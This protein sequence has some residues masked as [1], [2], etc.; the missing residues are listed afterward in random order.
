MRVL[1]DDLDAFILEM[2]G[3]LVVMGNLGLVVLFT[4]DVSMTLALCAG[5][6]LF[7]WC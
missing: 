3:G 1:R 4:G 2:D 7:L 5:P 6:L